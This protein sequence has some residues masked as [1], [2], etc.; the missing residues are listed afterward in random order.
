MIIGIGI[1]IVE[2]RRFR[3]VLERQK[4]RFTQR[5]FTPGEL[6][7]CRA[8][9]DPVPHFA[10]RF[11]AKEAL[12]KAL[13]T[14]WAREVSWLDVSVRREGQGAPTIALQGEAGRISVGMGAQKV[15]LSLSHTDES[16]V[17]VVVLES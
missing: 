14:G 5:V 4:E 3:A 6:E 7:Y 13:G 9:R 17:A 10:A 8:H 16:A 15:H 1:D 11:A 2:I 12:F